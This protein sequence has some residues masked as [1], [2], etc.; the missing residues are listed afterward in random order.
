MIHDGASQFA[1]AFDEVFRSDGTTIIRTPPYT[2]VANAFAERWVGTVRRELCD[3]VAHLEPT[4][5]H[6][7]P[8][9]VRRALQHAAAAPLPQSTRTERRRGRR[10]SARPTDP[11][12]PHLQRTHQRVPTSSL[13]A[14]RQRPNRPGDVDFD[15]PAPPARVGHHP[16]RRRSRADHVSGTDRLAASFGERVLAF[17]PA[18]SARVSRRCRR[19][20]WGVLDSDGGRGRGKQ[21]PTFVL[22]A[23]RVQFGF[24]AALVRL[25]RAS[26]RPSRC[27]TGNGSS[28]SVE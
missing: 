23:S 22:N 27:T 20:F 4:T 14:S 2:P 3:R 11:T 10:V 24:A 13:N 12:T 9:R 8:A 6:T 28:Q 16:R 19:M 18:V 7:T 5:P 25:P 26:I 17:R 15:A 21:V 1:G